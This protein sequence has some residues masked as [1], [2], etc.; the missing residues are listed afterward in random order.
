M[1]GGAQFE[2]LEVR[3]IRQSRATHGSGCSVRSM[4]RPLLRGIDEHLRERRPQHDAS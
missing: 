1:I 4:T 2:Y 3:G